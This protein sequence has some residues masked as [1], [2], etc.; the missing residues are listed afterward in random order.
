MYDNYNYPPGAD[1]PDAPWNEPVV[2]EAEFEVL[3]SQTLSKNTTVITDDYV[4]QCDEGFEDGVGYH[5]EWKDTSDTD[6]DA[7]FSQ[8]HYTPLQLI[9]MFKETLKKQLESWEGLEQTG[10]G[11]FEVRR[12]KHLIEE[13]EDWEEDE[14]EIMRA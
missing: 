12:I 13:C 5:D 8:E 10:K 3:C 1:T 6:W 4:P 11:S 7:A 14:T 9:G 2:P